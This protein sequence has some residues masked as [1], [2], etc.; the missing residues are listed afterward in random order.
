MDTFTYTLH[1]VSWTTTTP[2]SSAFFTEGLLGFSGSASDNDHDEQ[3]IKR[4]ENWKLKGVGL[5]LLKTEV[6]G[7]EDWEWDV[8][9]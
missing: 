8:Q 9:Y 6:R 7:M 3:Q 5:T 2:F 1:L 4:T